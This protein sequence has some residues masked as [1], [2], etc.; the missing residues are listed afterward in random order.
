MK[1]PDTSDVLKMARIG[2]V[3]VLKQ[4]RRKAALEF[5][6][7]AAQFMSNIDR[8]GGHIDLS[9]V[10]PLAEYI[11]ELSKEIEK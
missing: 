7:K 3:T 1:L 6:D 5:R 2:R 10:Q 11:N 8:D 4:A 9:W